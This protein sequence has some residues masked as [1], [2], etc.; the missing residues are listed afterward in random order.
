MGETRRERCTDD[1]GK[2]EDLL[3]GMRKYGRER[4]ESTDDEDPMTALVH[5]IQD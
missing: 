4:C 1:V 2:E 5:E 3:E